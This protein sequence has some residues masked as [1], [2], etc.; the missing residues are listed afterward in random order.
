MGNITFLLLL[1][2]SEKL[3]YYTSLSVFPVFFQTLF[4]YTVNNYENQSFVV[5]Q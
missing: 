5:E 3:S 4:L 2:F 1:L